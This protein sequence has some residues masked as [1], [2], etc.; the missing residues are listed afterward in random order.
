MLRRLAFALA[1]G[2][3]ACSSDST[4]EG[5]SSSSGGAAS[6][7]GATSGGS[8]PD[9]VADASADAALPS[10]PLE[11]PAGYTRLEFLSATREVEFE[12]AELVLQPDRDYVAVLETS[13][14]RIVLD[15]YEQQTPIAVNS[16]V[17]LALHHFYEQVA[18][19]RVIAGFMAQTGDPNSVAGRP[20]SWGNGGPGYSFTTES[21][22]ELKFDGP[23]MLGMARAQSRE[24]NGSQFFITFAAQESLDGEYTVWG[25]V[26][27][28]LEVLPSVVRGEPPAAPTRILRV[29]VGV[30]PR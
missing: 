18:F 3:L 4:G 21:V 22:A 1:S 14:G 2:L 19:H 29:A 25:K 28:G 26:T 15:L 9:A 5:P 8:V 16:F 17:F 23:G 10:A 6:S 7:S 30:K 11:V 24:S 12:R 13:S 20:S 27:E